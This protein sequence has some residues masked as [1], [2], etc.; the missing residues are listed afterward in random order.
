MQEVSGSTPLS[1]TTTAA[2]LPEAAVSIPEFSH[3]AETCEPLA[4]PTLRDC[5]HKL[6]H[7][8]SCTIRKSPLPS[9]DLAGSDWRRSVV[10]NPGGRSRTH[11]AGSSASPS[12]RSS[13]NVPGLIVRGRVF[14]LRLRVPRTLQKKVGRTH[15]WR[16]LGTGRW[17]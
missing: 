6:V 9:K 12:S 10:H 17:D 11:A 7:K 16:S 13:R 4:V 2:S 3:S 14:Y 8:R 5:D 1:S 15:F